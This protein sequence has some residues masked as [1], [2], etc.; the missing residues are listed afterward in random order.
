[1][2]GRY[3]AASASW[4]AGANGPA[5]RRRPA[6]PKDAEDNRVTSR[7]QKSFWLIRVMLTH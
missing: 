3:S 6:S 7:H 5:G 1:M 2:D 4:A